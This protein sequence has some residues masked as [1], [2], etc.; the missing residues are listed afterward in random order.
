MLYDVELKRHTSMILKVSADSPREA[1]ISAE[2]QKPGMRA[3]LVNTDDGKVG[4]DVVSHCGGCGD[5]ILDDETYSVD[6]D[7]V[8]FCVDCSEYD[9]AH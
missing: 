6:Q 5:P 3:A 1:A 2:Q 9:D 4:W 8:L 7:G